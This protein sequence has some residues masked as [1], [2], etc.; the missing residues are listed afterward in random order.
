LLLI[1]ALWGGSVRAEAA[2]ATP[3]AG[4]AQQ[5]RVLLVGNS[6]SRGLKP[7][8]RMA[9]RAR[10]VALRMKTVARGGWTLEFHARSKSTRERIETGGWDYVLLQ[11]NSAGIAGPRY[12]DARVLDALARGAGASTGFLMTWRDRGDPVEAYD[13]LR[14]QPGG[15]SGYIPIAYELGAF[16][17]PAGWAVRGAVADG[18][19]FDLWRDGHHLNTAGKYL[20][21]CVCFATITGASPVGLPVPRGVTQ[22]DAAY[23]QRRAETTVF[24]EASV[25]NLPTH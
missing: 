12:D 6:F 21:A 13:S 4:A 23:L 14:G 25:W 22:E 3:T 8:L 16:V 7:L 9:F 10:G 2:P 5:L 18:P 11:E 1:A 15:T 24:S 19:P 17:A 20:A